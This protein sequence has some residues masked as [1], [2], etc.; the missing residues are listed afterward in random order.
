MGRKNSFFSMN[1]NG[2]V[3]NA[4]FYTL[5]E[6]CDTVGINPLEWLT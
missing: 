1:D 6:S 5:I 4:I 3:Y 2:A